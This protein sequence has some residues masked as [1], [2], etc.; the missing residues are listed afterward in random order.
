MPD[1]SGNGFNGRIGKVCDELGDIELK[2]RELNTRQKELHEILM[3]ESRRT[4][5]THFVGR[6]FE[7]TVWRHDM[8]YVRYKDA[9][10][11]LAKRKHATD[12]EKRE[13][14]KAYTK[15]VRGIAREKTYIPNYRRVRA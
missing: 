15:R 2:M 1:G 3:E 11:L 5:E 8:E 14:L 12:E 10:E 6:R 4:K 7:T 13:V 9:F